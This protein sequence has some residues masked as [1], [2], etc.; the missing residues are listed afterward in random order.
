MTDE[1]WGEE[2]VEFDQSS[3]TT[4]KALDTFGRWERFRPYYFAIREYLDLMTSLGTQ[5]QAHEDKK[6]R[7]G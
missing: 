4:Q 1:E 7:R 6:E 3:L 5:N 2:V